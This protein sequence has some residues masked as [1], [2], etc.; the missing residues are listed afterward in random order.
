MPITTLYQPRVQPGYRLCQA[1]GPERSGDHH[2]SRQA[3][4]RVDH[5]RGV[6][7]ANWQRPRHRRNAGHGRGRGHRLRAA[8]LAGEGPS[9]CGSDLMYVLDTNVVSE[10]RKAKA[11][12][13]DP[14]VV[15]WA[16]NVPAPTLYLSVVTVLELE[17]GVL[18]VER[19]DP[20]Q[21]SLLRTWLVDHVLQRVCRPCVGRRY[22]RGGYVREASRSR[23]ESGPGRAHSGHSAGAWDE[24]RDTERRRLRAAGCPRSQSLECLTGVK[25][26]RHRARSVESVTCNPRCA[27]SGVRAIPAARPVRPPPG[28]H[29][30]RVTP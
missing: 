1:G 9:P 15:A 18:L 4:A 8:A 22:D 25:V 5:D 27:I 24:S 10:L 23:S 13:A 6:S 17:I 3:G 2:R 12:K 16:R 20:T 11:G 14:N 30:T 7:K 29:E 21:G 26:P 28:L 19:R